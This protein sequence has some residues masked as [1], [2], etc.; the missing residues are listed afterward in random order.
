MFQRLLA[1]MSLIISLLL[2]TVCPAQSEELL[3]TL[4]DQRE[5]GVT[6]Y[7]EN[8]ALVKDRR[9]ITLPKGRSDLVMREVSGRIRPETALL[10]SVSHPGALSLIEQNF[11]FDLLTPQKLVEKYV[12]RQVGVVKTHPTTG[13]ES[14]E[15]AR[16]LSTN[17]GVVLQIGDRIETGVPGRMVFP[18]VP[19]NLRDRPTLVV[20]LESDISAKQTM[21]LSYL[22]GGLSWKA[23]YVAELNENDDRL[24]INGWVTLTNTSGTTYKNAALQLVAGDVHQAPR[25][26]RRFRGKMAMDAV[27]EAAAP[28]M[29]E[30]SLLDFHLYTLQRPTTIKENQTKQ[31]ALLQAA[32]V[33]CGKE[34]LLFGRQYYYQGRYGQIGDKIKVGVYLNFENRK[35]DNLGMPLPKGVVRVYKKDRSSGLQFVGEDRIDHTPENEKVKL[36]LGDAFDVTARR[37]QTEFKKVAGFSGYNYVYESGFEIELKNGKDEDV[38]VKVV[39]PLPGD[40][41][42]LSSSHKYTRESASTAS[43]SVAVPAKGSSTLTYRVRVRY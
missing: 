11:D 13:E 18:E 7:N 27:M 9:E 34:Y 15:Q 16:V 36:K 5:V 32:G 33:R 17:N 26:E 42:M 4:A 35:E 37:K 39:E 8:L 28:S 2:I 41:K 14:I 10:R 22:T 20:K 1:G 3:S 30:E 23:D 19:A 12:G 38:E 31:V 29:T 24:D 25:A 21:E 6:I 40:W 43:W